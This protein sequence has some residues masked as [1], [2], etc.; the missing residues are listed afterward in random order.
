[1]NGRVN[2]FRI[3]HILILA[4]LSGTTLNYVSVLGQVEDEIPDFEGINPGF[5]PPPESQRTPPPPPPDALT[6]SELPPPSLAQENETD[7]DP[8]SVTNRTEILEILPLN[9]SNIVKFVDEELKN[10][11]G[12]GLAPGSIL[13][14]ITLEQENQ[15]GGNLSNATILDMLGPQEK[16]EVA[17]MTPIIREGG[18]IVDLEEAD[19]A[20]AN[21]TEDEG[22]EAV[23]PPPTTT[24]NE[25]S[26]D[27]AT[28]VAS[29]ATEDEGE[30]AV[31]PPPTTTTNETSTDNATNV[32]SR[33][34]EDEGEEAVSPP[35]TTTTN[36]TST[37]NA[38][39]VASRETEDEEDQVSDEEDEGPSPT[40][41]P[42]TGPEI[43]GLGN[44]TTDLDLNQTGGTLRDNITTMN[45]T[46][47]LPTTEDNSDESDEDNS[48]ESDEDNS[49]ED[50]ESNN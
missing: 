38:T 33:A 16:E 48:D 43:S 27:N 2:S 34:T 5:T 35:P 12:V 26:T 4:L 1:M 23:S 36:E 50:N 44:K 7:V 32:A 47:L 21:E 20:S 41:V 8:L 31:S 13:E 3:L 30:E 29:R 45:D 42:S 11:T 28:N 6:V 14:N 46:S 40:T 39:N 18:E 17:N 9:S 19:I 10:N 15:P 25:T 37:D 24:T 22:E 49:D